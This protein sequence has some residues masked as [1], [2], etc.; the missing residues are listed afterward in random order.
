[1]IRVFFN[2]DGYYMAGENVEI[3]RRYSPA[4][5]ERGDRI[6]QPIHHTYKILYN[7]LCDLR[8]TRIKE[9]V[10][11]FNDS[12][13]IDEI[14]GYCQPLDDVCDQW[15]KTIRRHVLPSIRSMVI[16]RKKTSDLIKGSIMD[17]HRTMMPTV[18]L[19]RVA[20]IIEYQEQEN[21]R[22]KKSA[23]IR[24]KQSWFGDKNEQ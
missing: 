1:M 24:L 21:M 4:I 13:I 23:A 15:L 19:K 10:I 6:F 2:E 16:F 22:R 11:V 3:S 7:A 12:R 14:N 5:T 9:D 17:G 18:D 8:D 20:D